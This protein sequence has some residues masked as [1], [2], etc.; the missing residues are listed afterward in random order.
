MAETG[1]GGARTYLNTIVVF[2]ISGLWHGA[3]WTFVLWGLL[4][5]ALSVFDRITAKYRKAIHPAFQWLCCFA[6]INLLWL[7][8]RADSINQWF[9]MLKHI[10][11]FYSTAISDGLIS[12]FVQP[13]QAFI[14]KL[15]HLWPISSRMRGFAMMSFLFGG[16]LICLGFENA[17][18]RQQSRAFLTAVISSALLVFSLTC[19]GQESVFVYFNF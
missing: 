13:E 11:S 17:C 9:G 8:F 16:I 12:C 19:I 1:R 18:R 14:I 6:A 7:L 2:L 15:L 3:N 10:A 4:H 5:G